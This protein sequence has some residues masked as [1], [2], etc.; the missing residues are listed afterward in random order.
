[1]KSIKYSVLCLLAVL[2]APDTVRSEPAGVNPSA[3]EVLRP[4]LNAQQGVKSFSGDFQVY[5]R[6]RVDIQIIDELQQ[7]EL[8]RTLNGIPA[9]NRDRVKK[10]IEQKW[11]AV[12]ANGGMTEKVIVFGGMLDVAYRMD[13]WTPSGRRTKPGAESD[14]RIV[15]DGTDDGYLLDTYNQSVVISSMKSGVPLFLRLTKA[16]SL[17]VVGWMRNVNFL[18]EKFDDNDPGTATVK[19]AVVDGAPAKEYSYVAKGATARLELVALNQYNGL[20]SSIRSVELATGHLKMQIE[21]KEIEE[22]AP[23]IFRPK[24]MVTRTYSL[25]QPEKY[26]EI[27]LTFS[28]IKWVSASEISPEHVTLTP[29]SGAAKVTDLRDS[30]NVVQRDLSEGRPAR[31]REQVAEDQMNIIRA[32]IENDAGGKATSPS[33]VGKFVV[34][35]LAAILSVGVVAYVY[36]GRSRRA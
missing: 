21:S 5:E 29:P 22:V 16:A 6:T 32:T 27:E 34:P 4:L 23:G 7:A 17:P 3:A 36:S 31:T 35:A 19:D 20:A 9:S 18:D 10:S 2:A 1:M 8:G 25:S 12:K 26:N 14:L 33:G 11:A 30:S 24:R 15:S 28:K 13:L